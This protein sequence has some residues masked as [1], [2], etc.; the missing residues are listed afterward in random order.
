MR[1]TFLLVLVGLLATPALT[2]G[3]DQSL[4]TVAE[5]TKQEREERRTKED[6]PAK[7]FSDSDL[8]TAGSAAAPSDGADDA[9][10]ASPAGKED[11]PDAG[12]TPEKTDEQVRAEKQATIQQKIDAEHE[13]M[14][15][16]D[17]RMA[18]AQ[19]ELADITNYTY[20][21][22]RAALQKVI[23]DGTAEKEKARQSIEDLQEEAR[24]LGVSVSP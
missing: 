18:E 13:R 12:K 11:K 9:D 5:R 3:D 21:A 15:D 1:V 2:R 20:G 6:K 22:H 23:D 7:S 14:Q 24:R 10:A 8:K 4:A 16:V 17:R 19:A